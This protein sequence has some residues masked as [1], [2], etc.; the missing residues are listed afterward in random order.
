MVIE[1]FVF[2]GPG[3]VTANNPKPLHGALVP[4]DRRWNDGVHRVA[5]NGPTI[6]YG[7]KIGIGA[8]LLPEIEIGREALV[9][10]GAVVT[11]SVPSFT[12]VRGVPT[13]EVGQVLAEDRYPDPSGSTP[14]ADQ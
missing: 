14:A 6:R 10:A 13:R 9:A 3:T 2:I 5:D 11:R 12:I 1:D 7:A 4:T 8:C